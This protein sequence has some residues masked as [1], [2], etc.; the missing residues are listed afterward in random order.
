MTKVW[1]LFAAALLALS[2]CEDGQAEPRPGGDGSAAPAASSGPGEA[3]SVER[4]L[5]DLEKAVRGIRTDTQNLLKA[6]TLM[7]E[8]LQ[9]MKLGQEFLQSE[10]QGLKQNTWDVLERLSEIA[11][12]PGEKPMPE[13]YRKLFNPETRQALVEAAAKKG[14]VLKEDRVEVPGVI[15]QD[16]AMLEFFAVVAGGK[17]HESI[18]ALTGNVDPKKGRPEGLAGM[19]NA[20]LL[21]LGFVKGKPLEVAKDETLIPPKGMTVHLYLEFP[22]ASGDTVRV[23]AEDLVYDLDTKSAMMRDPWVYIGSQFQAD[24]AG[25]TAY[26]ADLTGDVVSTWSWPFTIIDNITLSA[27]DDVSFVCY[28]DRIPPVGT[29][30]TMVFSK[31]PLPAKDFPASPPPGEEAEDDGDSG[32]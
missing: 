30:V 27:K 17:E 29:K 16:R 1:W 28:E 32:R 13:E 3:V 10:I 2:G 7:A 31:A 25:G 5:A 4:R 22:D 9:D 12:A 26:V 19:I 23:R 20:C 11:G 21:A 6:L 14:V 24:G 15:V 18:V 8:D